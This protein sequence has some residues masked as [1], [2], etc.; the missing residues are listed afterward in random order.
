MLLLG[1]EGIVSR[2]RFGNGDSQVNLMLLLGREGIANRDR[3]G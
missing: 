1:R 2:D 3:F